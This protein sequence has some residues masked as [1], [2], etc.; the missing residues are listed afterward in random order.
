MTVR[1]TVR[2]TDRITSASAEATRKSAVRGTAGSIPVPEI[3][4]IQSLS[5]INRITLRDGQT[6]GQN[7]SMAPCKTVATCQ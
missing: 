1:G 5:E 4:T 2:Q 7:H 3:G 6:D